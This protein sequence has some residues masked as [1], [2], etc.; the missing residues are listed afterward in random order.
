MPRKKETL[1]LSVPPGTK[2]KLEAIADRLDIRWGKNPS[3]SG[4][5]TAIAQQRV[6]VG[7]PFKLTSEQVGALRQAVSALIDAGFIEEAKS[8]ITLLIDT[9]DLEAPLRQSLIQTISQPLE[10][11][12]I[13]VDRL[14]NAQQPFHLIYQNAQGQML[15]YT[16]RYGSVIFYEKRYYLQI[17]CDETE[18][19]TDVPELRHNR[20]LRLDRI[21]GM[22]AA[23]GEWRGQ[24]D[25]IPVHL[26]FRGGLI[27]AYEPKVDD[28][29]DEMMDNVRHVTRNVIN[30]FWLIR[31]I[32]R[33]GADCVILS[34][35]TIRDRFKQN[36]LAMLEQYNA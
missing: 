12:R 30:S 14:I 1:T 31:E 11:W 16:A 6:D 19:S 32:H 28:V 29:R 21:Q 23:S 2:E 33:Y 18:D 20:C 36:L 34:P 3:P 5:V 25:T 26:A 24:F 22:V 17:W 13:E 35:P 15:E 9:G 10:G 4:L 27:R 7:Y 8:V